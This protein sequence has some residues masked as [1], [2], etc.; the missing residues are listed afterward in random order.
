MRSQLAEQD[1]EITRLLHLWRTG[2][3]DAEAA[4][5]ELLL[6]ELRR[7]AKRQFY[8]ERPGHTLQPTALVNEAF[9]RLSRSK[10]I[11]WQDR[12]HFFAI[13][14]RVMRR[15]LIDHARRR[16]D[17]DL[18]PLDSIPEGLLAGRS[19]SDLVFQMDA[20]LDKLEKE[21][22]QWCKV[23][24][25]KFFV[26]LTD[27]EAAQVLQIS[28]HTL[29]RQWYRARRWLYERLEATPSPNE[30]AQRRSPRKRNTPSP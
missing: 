21:N 25:L 5:F 14:G 30:D 13:A 20:L 12:S 19:R 22:A 2:D 8:R 29:Q 24:E 10:H 9:C 28:L 4:L 16:P 6:P 23:V 1:D 17:V 26:G 3:R 11:E 15:Y 18:I 7:M 27:E